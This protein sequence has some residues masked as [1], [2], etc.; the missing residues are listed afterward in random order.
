ML[1]CVGSQE[2]RPCP[3]A[4]RTQTGHEYLFFLRYFLYR[5]PA[6]EQGAAPKTELSATGTRAPEEPG[7]TSPPAAGASQDSKTARLQVWLL[8]L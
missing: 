6:H 2:K 4:G 5:T 3:Q 8:E 1:S 7:T